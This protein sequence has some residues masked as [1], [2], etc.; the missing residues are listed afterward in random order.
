MASVFVDDQ[1]K[2]LR[3]Y[4]DVLGFA[5]KHDIPLG[6]RPLAH[7]GVPAGPRRH[8]AAAGAQRA[9][10][11]AALQGRARRRRH[12]FTQFTVDDVKVEYDRL[13]ALGVTFTQEP[14]TWAR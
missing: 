13:R 1:E 3:F 9:P 12:P 6:G 2:A 14:L 5:T 8:R 7:R 11:G 4:V 10:G